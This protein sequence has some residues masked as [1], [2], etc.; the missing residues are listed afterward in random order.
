MLASR[1]GRIHRAR[2]DDALEGIAKVHLIH[3]P[4]QLA[5][6]GNE[7]A[8]SS[9]PNANLDQLPGWKLSNL[10]HQLPQFITTVTIHQSIMPHQLEDA[11]ELFVGKPRAIGRR[12]KDFGMSDVRCVGRNFP[13]AA[14]LKSGELKET[15]S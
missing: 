11:G 3:D 15:L 2:F 8:R 4:G 9:P 14:N 10:G 1:V 7:G 13:S 6:F 5:F 12:R